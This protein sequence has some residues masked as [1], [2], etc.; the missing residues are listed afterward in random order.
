MQ[1][2]LTLLLLNCVLV[3]HNI[4][5]IQ[6]TRDGLKNDPFNTVLMFGLTLLALTGKY[7]VLNYL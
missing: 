5:I 3:L 7:N 6:T 4:D 2:I 1:F